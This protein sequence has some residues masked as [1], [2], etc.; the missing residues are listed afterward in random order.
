VGRGQTGTAAGGRQRTSPGSRKRSHERRRGQVRRDVGGRRWP[1]RLGVRSGAYFRDVQRSSLGMTCRDKHFWPTGPFSTLCGNPVIRQRLAARRAS[2]PPFTHAGSIVVGGWSPTASATWG[3]RGPVPPANVPASAGWQWPF[4]A[5]RSRGAA[6]SDPRR[7]N[8]E[9]AGVSPVGPGAAPRCR[10]S[11]WCRRGS[12][13][14]VR[15]PGRPGNPLRRWCRSARHSS[16]ASPASWSKDTRSMCSI[17][18]ARRAWREPPLHAWA[19]ALAGRSP[20]RNGVKRPPLRCEFSSQA[21]S[22][23][24]RRESTGVDRSMPSS[25][26]AVDA[27]KVPFPVRCGGVLPWC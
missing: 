10:R 9:R 19:N 18:W 24:G 22:G 11:R 4:F 13:Q 16:A 20:R 2:V 3:Q 5:V 17:A 12:R 15:P 1:G 6:P 21:R 23:P 25:F 26:T 8:S 7:A 27:G 14:D